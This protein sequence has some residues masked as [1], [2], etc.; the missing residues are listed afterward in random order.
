M[1]YVQDNF[2]PESHLRFFKSIA[3]G[4]TNE[5]LLEHKMW[6]KVFIS[7]NKYNSTV[8]Q[9]GL[10]WENTCNRIQTFAKE[11]IGMDIF[12]YCF[13]L[14][15]THETHHIRKHQDGSVRGSELKNSFSSIIYINDTWDSTHGGEIIFS[16][17]KI[18]P[19]YNR[20]VF[21]SRDEAHEVF[22]AKKQWSKPR[23]IVMC[24]WDCEIL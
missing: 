18:E 12:P 22:P 24:S 23:A 8:N 19:V 16:D 21:Y 10:I 2:L 1:L 14:Q 6:K 11:K 13:R 4:V 20:L 3:E 5:Y 17:R 15:V 9:L 7:E